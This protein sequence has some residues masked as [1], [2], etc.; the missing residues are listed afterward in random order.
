MS[1]VKEVPYDGRGLPPFESLDPFGDK[2][3]PDWDRQSWKEPVKAADFGTENWGS[4]W[5]DSTDDLKVATNTPTEEKIPTVVTSRIRVLLSR[6]LTWA[7]KEDLETDWADVH[8]RRNGK[9]SGNDVR[10]WLDNDFE[11]VWAE[12]LIG[13]RLLYEVVALRLEFD[14]VNVFPRAVFT[15]RE[16]N[17]E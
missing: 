10:I 6:P 8:L 13:S 11:H 7:E 14:Y 17:G 9:H 2:S 1:K 16:Y 5:N 4:H 12:G 15:K 3:V